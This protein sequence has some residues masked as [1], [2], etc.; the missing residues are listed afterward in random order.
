[1]PRGSV[2]LR[3]KLNLS[4]GFVLKDKRTEEYR[5]YV[6]YKNNRILNKP[7]LIKNDKDLKKF[8]K[9]IRKLDPYEHFVQT[10]QQLH[11]RAYH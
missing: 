4:F 6:P 1:M 5:Y 2:Q 7:I 11:A 3:F 8:K 10:E 9:A